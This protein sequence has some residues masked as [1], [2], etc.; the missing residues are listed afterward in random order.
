MCH[1]SHLSNANCS[2]RPDSPSS[3]N[4]ETLTAGGRAGSKAPGTAPL[5]G[6]DTFSQSGSSR[7]AAVS[8]VYSS[9]TGNTK[10]LAEHLAAQL[11]NSRLFSADGDFPPEGE[12]FFVGFWTDKGTCDS[13][14]AEALSRLHG[15]NILLFGTAGFGQ[16]QSY[17]DQVLNRAAAAVPADSRLLSG[18]M[19]QGKMPPSV[20]QRYESQLSGASSKEEASRL[21]SMIE[22]FDSAASHPDPSDLEALSRWALDALD[23][24]GRGKQPC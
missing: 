12:T 18:F 4:G 3:R 17:F 23:R 11:P 19:C 15:K 7:N 14:A 1:L 8:I 2:K 6:R 5:S 20:R 24:A 21:A 22:N 13:Q 10:I 16:S 9:R